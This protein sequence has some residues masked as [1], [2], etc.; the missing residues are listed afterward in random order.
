MVWFPF[1]SL[2]ILGVTMLIFAQ[3]MPRRTQAGAEAAAK[4]EAFRRYLMEIERYQNVEEAKAI[5]SS[6]L[7]YAVAFGLERAWVRKFARVNTPAP[8]WYGPWHG[9]GPL[10]R[11]YTRT[12]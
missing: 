8:H 12:G 6:Y 1:V 3:Q 2:L 9:G 10:R 11:P 7:P 5:F 4:W